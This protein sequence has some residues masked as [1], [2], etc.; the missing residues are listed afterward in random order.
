MFTATPVHGFII[1]NMKTDQELYRQLRGLSCEQLWQEEVAR[2]DRASPRERF[3]RVAVIRA[4]GVAFAR[5]RTAEQKAAARAWLARL[6]HDPQEKIRRYAMGALPKLGAGR[7][8]EAE[9]LALLRTTTVA[10]EQKFLGRALD[11]LKAA[12]GHCLGVVLN[13]ISPSRSGYY[14]YA[15]QYYYYYSKDGKRREHSKRGSVAPLMGR[16]NATTKANE[17]A[18]P[19][20]A[21]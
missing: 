4:V 12:N 20:S 21:K 1:R 19:A 13:R 8:E 17:D 18:D 2:F 10:R 16:R 11:T 9:L 14:S 7:S 5:A 6:L 15:Y 3:Q